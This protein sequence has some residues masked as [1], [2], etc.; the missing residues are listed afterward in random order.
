LDLLLANTRDDL[1]VLAELKIENDRP[2]YFGLIQILMVASEF[3]SDAQRRRLKAHPGGETL[4]WPGGGPFVD[5]YIVGFSANMHGT[6]RQRSFD[7]TEIISEKLLR[8]DA[9]SR[10]VRRIAYLEAAL[11]AGGLTFEKRFAFGPGV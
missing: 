8:N 6:Y 5:L 3:Q 7:A 4:R 9:F 11:S 1:P 2:T 10:H